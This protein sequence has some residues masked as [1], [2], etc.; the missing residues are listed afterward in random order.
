VPVFGGTAG[1]DVIVGLGGRR[2][3]CGRGETTPSALV[4]AT[5]WSSARRRGASSS[6]A[7]RGT[8]A[9]TAADR[10][11][12]TADIV[13]GG[14][15][16]DFIYGRAL[17]TATSTAAL[18]VTLW[19]ALETTP[20]VEPATITWVAIRADRLYGGS[21]DDRIF[22]GLGQNTIDAGFGTDNCRKTK[23]A[24]GCNR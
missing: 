14:A 9:S 19:G 7:C 20:L 11:C 24:P 22:G 13:Y 8:T 12:C 21:G 15:D 5:T 3:N 2:W 10:T 17:A 6:L 4:S 23:H 18:A 16:R 1:D